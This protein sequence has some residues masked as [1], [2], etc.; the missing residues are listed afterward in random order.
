MNPRAPIIIIGCGRSGSTL[1][2]RVL[3][4]HP[5]IHMLG[6]TGFLTAR[7]WHALHK[8]ADGS[9]W[10]AF[11]RWHW[12]YRDCYQ[13]AGTNPSSGTVPTG[14]EW[15][16]LEN[17]RV[18]AI[19]NQSVAQLFDLSRLDKPL[20]GMK[21]IWNDGAEDAD[22]AIYDLVY[23]EAT[24]LH[25]VRHPLGYVRSAIG[26]KGHEI[27]PENVA[28]Q[29]DAWCRILR[30]SQRQSA[31][32]RYAEVRYED[33]IADP[34]RALADLWQLL[35]IQ[36][37]DDCLLPFRQNWMATKKLPEIDPGLFQECIDRLGMGETLASLGYE[38]L[39]AK[40]QSPTSYSRSVGYDENGRLIIDRGI[41][42]GI[43]SYW[44][45]VPSTAPALEDE[46]E[47][48]YGGRRPPADFALLED[49]RLLSRRESRDI[50]HRGPPGSYF[51]S[52][53][54]IFFASTDGSD[55]LTNGRCY[56]IQPL[57]ET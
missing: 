32:G 38:S 10:N 17:R 52:E 6:E 21:E 37:H 20:W 23:P 15:A 51:C 35:G 50:F 48:R 13:P 42:K 26:W 43:G 12:E 18:A 44:V 57:E 11:V 22:W 14:A 40:P 2:D 4:A 29:L 31:S 28:G 1:L 33:L 56:T 55:P 39:E 19:V 7:L 36:W 41:Q 27:T 47:R 30:T 16:E 46:I 5:S 8:A 54:A 24:W 25:L 9:M 45:F 3:D 53:A 34:R 49:G